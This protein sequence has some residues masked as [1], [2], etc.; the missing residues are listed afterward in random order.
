V[1]ANVDKQIRR[2]LQLSLEIT[3]QTGSA[4]TDAELAEKLEITVDKLYKTFE[5]ARAKHFVSI[6][7]SGEDFP[8]LGSSLAAAN[9]ATPGQQLEQTELVD[10]LTEA[11]GQLNERQR[12]IILL[13]YQ[14]QLT[15]S[16]KLKQWKDGR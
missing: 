5:N 14:Q 15:M 4:P 7:N 2:T 16:A 8:S 6:D 3:E 12:Q 1:P 9:T 13:Y 10:E 11:I